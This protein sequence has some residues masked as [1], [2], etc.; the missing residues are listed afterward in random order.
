MVSVPLALGLVPVS[1]RL[2]FV[3]CYA[4]IFSPLVVLFLI[5]IPSVSLSVLFLLVL[6][7]SLVVVAILLLYFGKVLSDP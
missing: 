6:L 5:L 2:S 4:V 7:R 1:L 3:H